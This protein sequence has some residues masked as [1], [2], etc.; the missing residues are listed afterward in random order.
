MQSERYEVALPADLPAKQLN[1]VQHVTAIF[2][3][4][5]SSLDRSLNHLPLIAE[6]KWVACNEA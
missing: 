3:C 1:C 4:L 6:W 2:L 5:A